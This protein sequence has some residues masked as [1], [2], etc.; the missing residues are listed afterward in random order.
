MV[1]SFGKILR[2]DL[3]ALRNNMAMSYGFSRNR[4]HSTGSD[5]L[6]IDSFESYQEVPQDVGRSFKMKT[7]RH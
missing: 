1:E 6:S 2:R 3:I 5:T 4:S 7:G